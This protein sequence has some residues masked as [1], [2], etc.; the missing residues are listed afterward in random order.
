MQT[1]K[2]ERNAQELE[3]GSKKPEMG[4]TRPEIGMTRP[5]M[6]M[7]KPEIG[8]TRPEIG[9]RKPEN[10]PMKPTLD[11]EKVN[12]ALSI[13]KEPIPQTTYDPVNAIF[14]NHARAKRDLFK[15]SRT[16]EGNTG[17]IWQRKHESGPN[18]IISVTRLGDILHVG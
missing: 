10:R 5:D 9:L 11:A 6:G 15:K 2:P 4:M 14:I 1:W 13:L 18:V 12:T 16:L 7:A 8:M 17:T 3:M